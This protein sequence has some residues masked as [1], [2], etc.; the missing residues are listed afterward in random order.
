MTVDERVRAGWRFD[1]VVNIYTDGSTGAIWPDLPTAIE[2]ESR[3]ERVLHYRYAVW[4][5][6]QD[7][8]QY[9]EYEVIYDV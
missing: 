5:R 1:G 9:T 8:V 6:T 7:S 4:R 2:V 3:G